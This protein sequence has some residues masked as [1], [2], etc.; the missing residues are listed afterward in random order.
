M[1]TRLML[2]DAPTPSVGL[3]GVDKSCSVPYY[4]LSRTSIIFIGSRANVVTAH[5]ISSRVI[6]PLSTIRCAA[7]N[8]VP[9]FTIAFSF[10]QRLYVSIKNP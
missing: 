5:A 1:R 4:F 2:R 6:S 7:S 9:V 3:T 10:F 8:G